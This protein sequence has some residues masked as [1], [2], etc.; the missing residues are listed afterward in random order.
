MTSILKYLLSAG[1]FYGAS[2]ALALLQFLWHYPTTA[3]PLF[4]TD[5]GPV[6]LL[7]KQAR[8]AGMVLAGECM[9][10][11]L[12][13]GN[14]PALHLLMQVLFSILFFGKKVVQSAAQ[15]CGRANTLHLPDLFVTQQ[16]TVVPPC[17][18][19]CE[20]IPAQPAHLRPQPLLAA[21]WSVD[22]QCDCH[23]DCRCDPCLQVWCGSH[24]KMQL[25][26][27][28]WLHPRSG[29]S[30]CPWQCWLPYSCGA[31]GRWPIW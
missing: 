19:S 3:T 24:S 31:S 28:G 18:C 2:A 13:Q 29:S 20:D 14:L 7:L 30:T 21:A 1:V 6:A 25:T 23:C 15:I 17:S 9:K 10:L 26:G 4:S 5:L 16:P 22:C 11:R 27:A 8:G 12:L